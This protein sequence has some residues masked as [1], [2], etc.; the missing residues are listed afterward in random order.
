MLGALW[1]GILARNCGLAMSEVSVTILSASPR[2]TEFA[3]RPPLEEDSA[4]IENW[5]QSLYALLALAARGSSL[6]L[7]RREDSQLCLGEDR[8]FECSRNFETRGKSICMTVFRH[9][10]VGRTAVPLPTR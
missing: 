1:P 8:G 2:S 6:R 9:A 10:R 7:S 4:S 3:Q 5:S